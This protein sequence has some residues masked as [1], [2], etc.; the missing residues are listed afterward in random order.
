M[1]NRAARIRIRSVRDKATGREMRVITPNE[2]SE[3]GGQMVRHARDIA[4][5]IGGDFAGYFIVGFDRAGCFSSAYRFPQDMSPSLASA[6]IKDVAQRELST[7]REID[8]VLTSYGII[9]K[10]DD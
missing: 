10:T 7:A 1:A 4:D 5:I 2:V 3:L 8:H 6:Y 9:V